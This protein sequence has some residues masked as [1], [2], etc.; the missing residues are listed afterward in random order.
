MTRLHGST[1]TPTLAYSRAQMFG[2]FLSN[3]LRPEHCPG[4]T[5]AARGCSEPY[6]LTQRALRVGSGRIRLR[7][8]ILPGG[9]ILVARICL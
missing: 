8:L 7:I 6:R 1:A 2:A 5:T 9:S 3:P 4:A